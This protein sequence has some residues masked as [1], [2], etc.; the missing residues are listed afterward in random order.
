MKE[1]VMLRLPLSPIDTILS[2]TKVT[3]PVD[4]E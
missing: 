2:R 4:L 1:R 3:E